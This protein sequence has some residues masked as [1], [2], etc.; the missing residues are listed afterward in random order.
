MTTKPLF[1]RRA[2]AAGL[3]VLA[4]LAVRPAAAETT[5]GAATAH[6]VADRGHVAVVELT[7]GYDEKLANGDVNADPREAVAQELF[8]SHP[9][10]YDFLI[11]WSTFPFDTHEAKAFCLPVL[12]D[13]QGIGMPLFD[14]SD[15]F[16]SRHKLQAY[17][18]M[19]ALA[20]W[21]TDPL[22]PKFEDTLVVLSH[23]MLHRW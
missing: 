19:A 15:L 6:L 3:L 23:E 22:A 7:G 21:A 13:V 20:G 5:V 18:D 11:V 14:N 1:F 10:E 8:K 9:D 2:L 17:V 16:G 4:G 12:N